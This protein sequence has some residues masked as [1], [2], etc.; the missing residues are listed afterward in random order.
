MEQSWRS[1]TE[2]LVAVE[3]KKRQTSRRIKDIPHSYLLSILAKQ[4]EGVKKFAPD[5]G[6]VSELPTNRKVARP[7]HTGAFVGTDPTKCPQLQSG[8]SSSRNRRR[9]FTLSATRSCEAHGLRCRIRRN[10][11]VTEA[12]N[13]STTAMFCN[14]S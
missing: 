6:P 3:I 4:L 9:W 13:V 10:Y 7:V 2:L 5:G 8:P 11:S 12:A 14:N 1:R